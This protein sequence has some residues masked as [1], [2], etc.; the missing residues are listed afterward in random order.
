M[1]AKMALKTLGERILFHAGSLCRH[2]PLPT[3]L[4]GFTGCDGTQGGWVA[5][6]VWSCWPSPQPS[7]PWRNPWLQGAIHPHIHVG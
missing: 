5:K 6:P 3:E 4:W 1:T 7:I 2:V